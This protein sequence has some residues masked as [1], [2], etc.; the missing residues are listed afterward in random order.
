MTPPNSGYNKEKWRPQFPPK[1]R[2]LSIP[3]YMVAS[4]PIRQHPYA[5][6]SGKA[7]NLYSVG[8]E[9]KSRPGHLVSVFSPQSL[10]V[11]AGIVL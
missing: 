1:H 3:D 7:L 6:R 5:P 2:S 8:T 9:F 10:Q 4:H 11:N